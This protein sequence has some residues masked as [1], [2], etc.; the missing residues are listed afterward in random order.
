MFPYQYPDK[1][2]ADYQMRSSRANQTRALYDYNARRLQSQDMPSIPRPLPPQVTP[3]NIR[4]RNDALMAREELMRDRRMNENA[5]KVYLQEE[6]ERARYKAQM[7]QDSMAF[8]NEL[9]GNIRRLQM[10]KHNAIMAAQEREE[11]EEQNS[12][13][14]RQYREPAPPIL[15]ADDEPEEEVGGYYGNNE[16]LANQ[17]MAEE[18]QELESRMRSQVA[19]RRTAMQQ[20]RERE[21]EEY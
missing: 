1:P 20:A 9:N 5:R 12:M 2:S 16:Y 21:E 3:N 11:Q 8:L 7:Q 13:A 10:L 6:M 17:H 18:Q 15:P 4:K 19:N 14:A